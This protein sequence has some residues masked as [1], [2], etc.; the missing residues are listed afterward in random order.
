MSQERWNNWREP[1]S[2]HTI[3][4]L[5]ENIAQ[6]CFTACI[7]FAA[8]NSAGSVLTMT[9]VYM[10]MQLSELSEHNHNYLW[11]V[12]LCD[13]LEAY[14]FL[15]LLLLTYKCK[16]LEAPVEW[17][18]ACGQ[19]MWR[20][21]KRQMSSYFHWLP[22]VW[23]ATQDSWQLWAILLNFSSLSRE[24]RQPFLC[25]FSVKYKKIWNMLRG[26]THMRAKKN[27]DISLFL[28][29]HIYSIL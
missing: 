14:Y 23:E 19:Q 26:H 15:L 5:R 21:R 12:N 27:D 7:F 29:L 9:P 17:C 22:S 11:I 25:S 28:F 18:W 3:W 10:L 1:R 20:K 4:V 24:L 8:L 2:A 6:Q 13:Q 16:C